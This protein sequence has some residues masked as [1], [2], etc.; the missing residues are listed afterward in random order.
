MFYATLSKISATHTSVIIIGD[1]NN[2]LLTTSQFADN[3]LDFFAFKQHITQP[4]RVT[5]H[6]AMLLDHIYASNINLSS[7]NAC[8]LFL[9][10]HSATLCSIASKPLTVN[11]G[12]EQHHRTTSF[13]SL[14]KLNVAN[15][16]ADLSMFR[17][18]QLI[19]LPD[20]NS[21]VAAFSE[22]FVST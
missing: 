15:L 2:D 13:C 12:Q 19:D 1:F 18:S 3:I 21:V 16:L 10:N 22:V 6:S 11:G 4:T 14:K 5:E 20:V 17:I 9:A 7:T 8:N